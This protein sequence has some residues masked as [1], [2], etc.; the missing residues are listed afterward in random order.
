M[1]FG[2][3]KFAKPDEDAHINI[4]FNRLVNGHA[5]IVGGSGVG[6]THTI[7]RFVNGYLESN[8]NTRFHIIDPHGDMKISEESYVK[9]SET[10]TAGLNP[11]Q[12]YADPDFGGVR[13][14]VRSILS[15][16][17]RSRSLGSKQEACLINLMTDLFIA[18]GFYPE[19]PQSWNVNIDVRQNTKFPKKQ[20]T[21]VDLKK[22]A[23]N[24]LKQ[25]LTGQNS[26]GVAKLEELFKKIRSLDNG[27]TNEAKGKEV[28][29]AKLKSD[30]IN[31]YSEYVNNIQTGR[32][33]DEIIKYNSTDVLKSVYEKI[34]NLESTGIFKTGSLPFDQARNCW[35]YDIASLARDEQQMFCDTLLEDLFLK[36]KMSGEKTSIE[37]YIVIDEGSI[38][39]NED[40]EHIIN[41]IAKEGRKFGIAIVVASQSY[42]HFPDDLIANL[43]IKIVLAIDESFH[44]ATARKL[45][46]EPKRLTYIKPRHSC[47]IQLKS[48]GDLSNKFLDC[49]LAN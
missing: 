10:T 28:D 25:M 9:F 11:L 13:K 31:A 41:I 23:E 38:F 35:R 21:M 37:T 45:K 39:M 7:R 6:K 24:K 14:K 43:A 18:N 34:C 12:I 40:P 36:S 3:N 20:P 19:N 22:F 42:S 15:A 46:I 48:K 29:V 32:E 2:T 47:L 17:N 33:L 8:S 30:C 4:D 49:I 27:F 1:I 26:K 44:D 5:G 16:I